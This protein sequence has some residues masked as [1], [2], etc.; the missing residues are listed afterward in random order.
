[1]KCMNKKVVQAR[2]TLQA[3]V[4]KEAEEKRWNSLT[5]EEQEKELAQREADAARARKI[6]RD[7]AVLA[8][9]FSPYSTFF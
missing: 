5:P 3:Q 2:Q 9:C 6:L 7:T 8:S 4:V 1:M